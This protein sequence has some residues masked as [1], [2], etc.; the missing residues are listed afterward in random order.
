M[1]R[2]LISTLAVSL[3]AVST[4]ASANPL[5]ALKLSG[6]VVAK[7]ADG[8]EKATPLGDAALK[9]GETIRYDISAF[10]KGDVPAR[11]LVPAGK[12]PA[13]TEYE[14]GTAVPSAAGLE[15]SINDGKTWSAK[16]MVTVHTP[17]GDV[18]KPADPATY[19]NVRWVTG[20]S[21]AVSA[22][23]TFSYEVLVK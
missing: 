4:V 18:T 9:P 22:A 17:A 15:F 2:F 11:S 13:G 3:A 7:A 14:S 10:N 19:T 16:P 8:T 5:V 12:V 21:L 1:R 20:K 23:S 6:S